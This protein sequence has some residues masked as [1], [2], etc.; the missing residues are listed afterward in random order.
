M[1]TTEKAYGPYKYK[2]PEIPTTRKQNGRKE[3][4]TRQRI[5]QLRKK[6]LGR[7]MQCGRKRRFNRKFCDHCLAKGATMV[8]PGP[9]EA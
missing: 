4:V 7:C 8:W 1:K 3:F 5:W 6:R 9:L 2:R